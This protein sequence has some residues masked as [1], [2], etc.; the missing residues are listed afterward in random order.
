MVVKDILQE[1][2][3]NQVDTKYVDVQ[4]EAIHDYPRVAEMIQ[5]DEV[6]LPVVMMDDVMIDNGNISYPRIMKELSNKGVKEVG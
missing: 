1:R 2:Y 5:N 3:G 4:D 6:Y